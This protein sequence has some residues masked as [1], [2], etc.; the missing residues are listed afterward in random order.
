MTVCSKIATHL[1]KQWRLAEVSDA[2][3]PD[4][5]PD[6][7]LDEIKTIRVGDWIAETPGL[8]EELPEAP[9]IVDD[10]PE[11]PG[12][13][14]EGS[15]ESL[16]SEYL[17]LILASPAYQWLLA[18]LRREVVLNLEDAASMVAI[19]KA[20]AFPRPPRISA[21]RSVE[22]FSLTFHIPWDPK[23]FVKDQNYQEKPE[24]AICDAIT[25]TG[26]AK[27]AQALTTAQYLE[28]TWPTTGQQILQLIRAIVA[29]EP[30][31]QVPC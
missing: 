17:K 11:I 25:L 18:A 5:K 30:H 21:K 3:D 19:R 15:L 22:I 10:L 27:N 28:Q 2:E 24:D 4:P 6:F 1:A 13:D 12:Q 31:E 29:S 14:Q 7:E 8:A 26:T 23:Q 9:E 16:D 20:I